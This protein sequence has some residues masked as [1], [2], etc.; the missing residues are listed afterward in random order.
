MEDLI[1][2]LEG[3]EELFTIQNQNLVKLLPFFWKG[4]ALV[5]YRGHTSEF[6]TWGKVRDALR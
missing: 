3:R 5:W 4:G 6:Q 2:R 1:A